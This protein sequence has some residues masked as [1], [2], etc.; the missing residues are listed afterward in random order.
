MVRKALFSEDSGEILGLQDKLK[1]M[2]NCMVED[3]DTI[4]AAFD[5][6]DSESA[7]TLVMN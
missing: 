6:N 4:L 3:A 7:R 1:E 2:E 5:N